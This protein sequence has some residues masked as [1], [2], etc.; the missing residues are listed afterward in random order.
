MRRGLLAAPLVVLATSGRAQVLRLGT[1]TTVEQ[2]GALAVVDSLWG[3]P[4]LVTIGPSGQILRAAADGDVDVVIT[5]APALEAKW[6]TGRALLRCPFVAS[7]FAIVGPT[8]DPAAVSDAADA[9]DA[10]RRIAKRG[11]VFV[12]RDDSSGTHVKELALWARAGIDPRHQAWYL[13]S[14]AGQA[15]T[16]QI[17]DDRQGYALADLPTFARVQGIAMQVLFARDPFLANPYTLYV[18]NLPALNPSA[19][20]FAAFAMGT[21]R[22]HLLARHLPDGSPAFEPRE[23]ACTTDTSAAPGQSLLGTWQYHG[24]GPG[25]M[26]TVTFDSA[27]GPDVYGH[28]AR[29]F[30][31]DLGLPANSFG[32]VVGSIDGRVVSFTIPFARAGQSSIDVRGE[33]DGDTLTIT[34]NTRGK[35]PGPFTGAGGRFVRVP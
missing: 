12:S 26:V 27:A 22:A 18:I 17:A 13:E 10:L 8:G 20:R 15:A 31:G 2:S 24:V 25:V 11:A 5:H 30:A 35:D 29:W 1:T 14:G 23:G 28:M 9:A 16:L 7:R 6:L 34:A 4:P 3:D 33:L 32:R 21:W 19:R